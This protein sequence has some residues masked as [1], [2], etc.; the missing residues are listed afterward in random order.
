VSYFKKFS[1]LFLCY[2][3]FLQCDYER[4]TYIILFSLL[5]LSVFVNRFALSTYISA[6][7]QLAVD[8]N[9]CS[10]KAVISD[11]YLGVGRGAKTPHLKKQESYEKDQ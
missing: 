4:V 1:L 8:K 7:F 3:T 5:L 6:G 10:F 2:D 11:R 9:K